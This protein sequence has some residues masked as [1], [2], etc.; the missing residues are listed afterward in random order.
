MIDGGKGIRKAI[1]AVFGQW[2]LIQRCQV[3][4]R[5]NV[6]EHLPEG[7][8]PWVRAAMNRAWAAGDAAAGRRALL[9]LADQIEEESPGAAGALREGLEETLT[10]TALGVAGALHRTLCSTNAIENML[11]TI[12]RVTRNVKRWRGGKMALRWAVAA[13]CEAESRFHRVRGHRG[14]PQLIHALEAKT[15]TAALDIVHEVA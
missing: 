9:R 13:L 12:K 1:R 5:R 2:A 6:L 10:L 15:G 11:G 14:L 8:R 7:R 4:K 3:H